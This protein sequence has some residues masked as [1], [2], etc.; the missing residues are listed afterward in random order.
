[1]ENV[2][3]GLK[4]LTS[5]QEIVNDCGGACHV[6]GWNDLMPATEFLKCMLNKSCFFMKCCNLNG[7]MTCLNGNK[8]LQRTL[9]KMLNLCLLLHTKNFNI[10]ERTAARIGTVSFSP[11]FL[12]VWISITFKQ[13]LTHITILVL[14]LFPTLSSHLGISYLDNTGNS[15]LFRNQDFILT[16]SF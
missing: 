13:K 1:M 7:D 9:M 14:I 8:L 10:P 11:R 3:N 12:K 15:F 6:I 4:A 16:I 2:W 5:G